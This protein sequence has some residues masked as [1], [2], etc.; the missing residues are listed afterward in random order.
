KPVGEGAQA[1]LAR[2]R[3]RARG[4]GRAVDAE[5]RRAKPHTRYA[6]CMMFAAD[7]TE[8]RVLA[9]RYCS[10]VDDGDA[11]RMA[12]LFEPPGRLVVYAPG[13]TPGKSEPLRR[14]EGEQ[15]F[16]RLITV[17]RESYDRWVHFLGNHSVE[18]DGDRAAGE[19]YLLSL[20]L[21]RR[22]DGTEE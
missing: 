22:S 21:R 18:V 17:L 9:S 19:A 3:D 6:I 5:T 4:N 20:G 2:S 1:R 7:L 10:A 11:A 15:D 16:A 8:T 12:S 14:W 13:S